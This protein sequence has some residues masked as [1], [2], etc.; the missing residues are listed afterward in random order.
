[1]FQR[2]A[3]TLP[4]R[5][6]GVWGRCAAAA[7]R[8]GFMSAP[9][10]GS[11]ARMSQEDEVTLEVDGRAVR[12]THPDKPYFTRGVQLSKLDIVNYYLAVAPGAVA[13]IRDRPIVLK[14]FV[15][16]ADGQPFY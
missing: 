14:R 5:H 1:M 7:R 11:L 12:V 6:S 2:R 10:A 3:S 15:D 13:P 8:G 16:G 9:G 4:S